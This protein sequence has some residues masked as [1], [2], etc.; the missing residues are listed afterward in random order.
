MREERK[1]R[2]IAVGT[3]F[4][5]VAFAAA[6]WG[7][8]AVFRRALALELPAASIV[9]AEHLILVLLCAPLW[10]RAARAVRLFGRRDWASVILIG[11]GASAVAT[12]LFTAAFRYGDPTT[13]LLL[14]KVQPIVAVLG[15]RLLLGERLLPR[16][17]LYFLLAVCGAYFITFPSPTQV[18]VAR[19]APALLAVGAASLWGMGT[20]LGR[21]MTARVDVPTLTALRFMFGL[22]ASALMVVV[23]DGPGGF[24]VYR[25]GD[26]LPL[27]LLALVPGL[28]SLALY[29]RGLSRTPAAAATLAELAFPLSAILINY[30][31]FR[32]T[33]TTT[34]WVGV[35]VLSGTITTMGLAGQRSTATMGIDLSHSEVQRQPVSTPA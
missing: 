29:Y 14:Q 31:A 17:A 27:L 11:V 8:D 9:F 20:V 16:Y 23:M 3:G 5:L 6:L 12:A 13:P 19:L 28:L 26:A 32:Q 18:S 21:G 33:L 7:T 2:H 4:G 25:P 30:L 24:R 35:A 1:R 22:P 10:A 34:Q 15:A